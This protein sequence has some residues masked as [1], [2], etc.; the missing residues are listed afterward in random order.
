MFDDYTNDQ[1]V[2]VDPQ[3]FLAFVEGLEK[4]RCQTVSKQTR[5]MFS[6]WLQSLNPLPPLS[7]KTLVRFLRSGFSV[8]CVHG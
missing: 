6:L 7:M 8:E 1:F 4:V 5:P 2:P 3:E